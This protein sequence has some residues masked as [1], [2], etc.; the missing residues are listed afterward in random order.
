[1]GGGP[2]FAVFNN[3]RA[4]NSGFY[5]L[6]QPGHRCIVKRNFDDQP[7]RPSAPPNK[8]THLGCSIFAIRLTP[9]EA[10]LNSILGTYQFI[11]I[12]N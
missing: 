10:R 12:Y 5:I 6:R 4:M 9:I 7:N 8:T 11:Y 3:I 2:E 1:M